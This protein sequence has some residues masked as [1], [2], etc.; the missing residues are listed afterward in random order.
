MQFFQLAWKLAFELRR[1]VSQATFVTST[2]LFSYL[3]QLM[4]AGKSIHP[5]AFVLTLQQKRKGA[6][7][8]KLDTGLAYQGN[9]LFLLPSKNNLFPKFS[10]NQCFL[11][12]TRPLCGQRLKLCVTGIIESCQLTSERFSLIWHWKTCNA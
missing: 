7:M 8:L 3:K 11:S 10:E 6:R 9:D 2:V 1:E 5:S 12:V 4:K